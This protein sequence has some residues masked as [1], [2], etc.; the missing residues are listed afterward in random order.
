MGNKIGKLP[1]HNP[2]NMVYCKSLSKNVGS[3]APSAIHGP[4][5]PIFYPDDKANTPQTA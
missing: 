1:S 5:G 2:S 3:K 4:L